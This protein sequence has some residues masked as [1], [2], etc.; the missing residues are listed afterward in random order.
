MDNIRMS[1]RVCAGSI[2]RIVCMPRFYVA[3]LWLLLLYYPFMSAVRAFS[4]AVGVSMA[5]WMFPFLTNDSGSQ[6]FII[7]GALLL[8]CD[9]PFLN[10]NSSWQI[11]RAGRK[12]W[13][14]GNMLYIWLLSLIYAIVISLL[15]VLMMIP[16][17]EWAAGWGK[18][19]GTLAQ[20]NALG[21]SINYTIVAHFSPLEA[22]TLTILAVWLNAVLIGM[23]NFILNL[24]FRKGIGAAV[25]VM[26]GLSPLLIV[27]LLNFSMG[28][29]FAPPLWMDLS[30]YKW[31]GYGYGPSFSYVYT[32]LLGSI[33]LCMILSL[34][35]IRKKDLNF[36]EEV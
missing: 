19:L 15:P 34:I 5:P 20:T 8:F 7:L 33:A 12:N 18:L 27:R 24:L 35:G 16:Q 14:W 36:T 32:V 3:F 9:A 30:N 13:F 1:V 23:L 29:Y 31:Q 22:M 26:I 11:L 6:M 2:R 25:S 4:S 17:I 21:L 28:Y 10:Q